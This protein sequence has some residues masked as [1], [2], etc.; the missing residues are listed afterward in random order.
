MNK[1]RKIY[2]SRQTSQNYLFICG[3]GAH[4]PQIFFAELELYGLA[5]SSVSDKELI[6]YRMVPYFNLVAEFQRFSIKF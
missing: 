4:S 2:T 5:S 3:F 6:L 1:L